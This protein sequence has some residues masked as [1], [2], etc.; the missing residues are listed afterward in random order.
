MKG[1]PA[2][3]V[4]TAEVGPAEV[5]LGHYTVFEAEVDKGGAGQIEADIRPES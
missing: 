3:P 1:R 5:G 4:N 2:E